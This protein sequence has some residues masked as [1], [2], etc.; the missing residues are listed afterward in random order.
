MK[1]AICLA[2]LVA[3]FAVTPALG[4]PGAPPK[5]LAKNVIVMISDGWGYNHLTAVSYYEYGKDARQIYNRFPFQWAMSTYSYYCSYDP[6]LAWGN[7]E[8][9]KSCYT[10]SA[11]AATAMAC[12]RQNLRCSY[13]RRR[14]WESRAKRPRA[15]GAEGQG[16][17]R[18]YQRGMDP[19]HA[20]R[21]RRT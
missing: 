5:P 19:R 1:K 20:G 16:H 13:R 7:F 8:Y 17:G 3:I 21:S 14:R 6:A 12:R 15:G 10:D 2:L 11:A 4:A 9:V 18:C